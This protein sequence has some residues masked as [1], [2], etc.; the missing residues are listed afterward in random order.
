[1]RRRGE[2]ELYTTGIYIHRVSAIGIDN[3]VDL[4]SYTAESERSVIGSTSRAA[5]IVANIM[6]SPR[7]R[8]HTPSFL[9]SQN[10]E[11]RE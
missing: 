9:I 6:R 1:M 10:T 2:R 5:S 7:V 3:V 8:S 4:R 11:N